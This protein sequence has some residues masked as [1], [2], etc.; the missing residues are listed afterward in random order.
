MT[1]PMR[2]ILSSIFLNIIGVMG[3]VLT[4]LLV[5]NLID[6]YGLS[7]AQSGYF[8]TA[9]T[10][11]ITVSAVMMFLIGVRLNQKLVRVIGLL[12]SASG[13]LAIGA[14]KDYSLLLG[15]AA[16]TG[17]GGGVLS[18][19]NFAF[20]SAT[21]QADKNFS[22]FMF[23]MTSIGAIC[24][25]SFTL[26]ASAFG[27]E[28]IFFTLAA[29]HLFALPLTLCIEPILKTTHSESRDVPE[30][31]ELP[32]GRGLLWACMLVFFF[33]YAA[34]GAFWTY[35]ERIGIAAGLSSELVGTL[36]GAGIVLALAGCVAAFRIG[37]RV[38]NR[39]PLIFLCIS[40][41]FIF[42]ALGISSASYIYVICILLFYFQWNMIDI[43]ELGTLNLISKGGRYAALVPAFQAAGGVAGPAI[44]ASF[45]AF[46][47][48]LQ[49]VMFFACVSICAALALCLYL[50]AQINPN[51]KASRSKVRAG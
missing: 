32:H 2:A 6:G 3:F 11:G 15:L 23:L 14:V 48:G 30:S 33:T 39:R 24:L 43:F 28:F 29:L 37:E 8:I 22:I 19:A 25:V 20:L 35:A 47:W 7:L 40:F 21:A 1:K 51:D 10:F 16:I 31:V 41:S 38:G 50:F 45:L 17:F 13:W 46:G 27:S 26:V 44:G 49:S 36:L 12:L 34:I 9:F 5:G 4:P 42:V 18:S